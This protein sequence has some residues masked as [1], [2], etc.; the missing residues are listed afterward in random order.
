MNTTVSVRLAR[1]DDKKLW[2]LLATHP[3]QSWA[4][5]E[6]R[7]QMNVVCERIIVLKNDA[8]ESVFLVTFHK[9]PKTQASVAYCGKCPMPPAELLRFIDTIGKKHNAICV[10]FEPE[11]LPSQNKIPPPADNRF[12]P[13]HHPLFTPYTFLLDLSKTEKDL[14][15]N[16]HTK[17]RY[18]IRVAQKH[19]VKISHDNS[20]SAFERFLRLESETTQRQGFYAHNERYK[21][22]MWETM[23]HSDVA[24]IWE[25]T[26]NKET[27]ASWI[28]FEWK[29][30]IYYPYGAS[31]RSHR[32]VMAPTLLMWEIAL[33]A[34]K[35]GKTV[36]DLW[37]A[38]GLEPDTHDSWY[39]FHRFKEGFNP[40]HAHTTDSYDYILSPMAYR[41]Y[42]AAD[43]L[44][45]KILELM[46]KLNL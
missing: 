40:V 21:R 13:S 15:A 46:K 38:L 8:P 32:E 7:K 20:P 19:G 18:N 17:T 3:I 36:F 11:T 43:V 5:G 24:H 23:N 31:S 1:E 28:I 4:W 14:L 34:K 44:R 9:V 29:N 2:D 30:H 16:M 27:L 6:F 45:W 33:W 26:Y 42:T 37:G 25:A 12:I 22:T 39:G 41:L 10:Q 35:N